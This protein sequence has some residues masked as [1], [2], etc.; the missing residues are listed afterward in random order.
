MKTR[1]LLLGII[2]LLITSNLFA[3]SSLEK[4]RSLS[5][6]EL[7]K[8]GTPLFEIKLP[9][10][11]NDTVNLRD[12]KGKYLFI[13]IWATW[14]TGCINNMPFNQNIIDR[15]KENNIEFI[16]ISI[17]DSKEK[18]ENYV[19]KNDFKGIHLFANGSKSK[20]ICY[21]TNRIYEE[22]GNIKSIERGIPRYILINPDGII[23]SNDFEKATKEKM[24]DYIDSLLLKQ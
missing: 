2:L 23:L 14:C 5:N 19:T 15:Y 4:L 1:V 13:N 17:D 8:E 16:M 21:F 7:I 22:N 3:Q 11:N 9:T 6:V 18:W 12:F 10:I 24:T 20:P